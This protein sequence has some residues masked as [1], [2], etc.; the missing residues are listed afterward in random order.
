MVSEE[1]S[2][3]YRLQKNLQEVCA[4]NNRKNMLVHSI[5]NS[6]IPLKNFLKVMER[7]FVH[8]FPVSLWRIM[9]RNIYIEYTFFC[10]FQIALDAIKIT[11]HLL[12][13]KLHVEMFPAFVIVPFPLRISKSFLSVM[14]TSSEPKRYQMIHN[15]SI[16]C[17][18][19]IN[20]R[21]PR[22][23]SKLPKG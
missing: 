17:W 21:V 9:A 10:K 15:R 6:W 18:S 8:L 23:L 19:S 3:D 11:F 16:S 14:L 1:I 22:D 7:W 2:S 13:N 12:P 5:A 4:T 20:C